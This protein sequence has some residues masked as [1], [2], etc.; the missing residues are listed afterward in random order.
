MIAAAA[1]VDIGERTP[2]Q[3]THD[4]RIDGKPVGA[5][6]EDRS[7]YAGHFRFAAAA[8]GMGSPLGW[9]SSLES[10]VAAITEV[11]ELRSRA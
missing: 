10:A 9:H 2:H 8:V 6:V 5:V 4:V 11:H 1:K 3:V 7:A